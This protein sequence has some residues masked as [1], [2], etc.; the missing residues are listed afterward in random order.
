MTRFLFAT[1]YSLMPLRGVVEAFLRF[2]LKE[3]VID[4]ILYKNAADLLGIGDY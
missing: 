3:S 2:P 4:R 1:A